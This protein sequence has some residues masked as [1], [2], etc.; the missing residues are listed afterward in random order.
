MSY[1]RDSIERPVTRTEIADHLAD[2]FATGPATRA[3][4]VGVATRAGARE[5]VVS[6]IQSL[7]DGPYQRLQE[8]WRD[9]A[10]VPVD[11]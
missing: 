11:V 2:A 10:H 5:Q 1:L 6:M 4:L 8:L 3:E 9:L 7:P